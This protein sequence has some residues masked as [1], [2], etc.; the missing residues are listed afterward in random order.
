MARLP[1]EQYEFVQDTREKA[2]T[3]RSARRTRT[4]CGKGG[5]V[6]LP[7]DYMTK[8]ELEAMNGEC[9]SYRMNDSITWDEFKTW[10]KEH[11]E[12][13]IKLIRK[14]F[15]APISAISAMFGLYRNSLNKYI[16]DNELN[17][18]DIKAKRYTWDRDGFLAWCGM[19]KCDEATTSEISEEHEEIPTPEE[20]YVKENDSIA[21]CCG[22][23]EV[24]NAIPE[25]GEMTF[26][27]D[28]ND[29]LRTIGKLLNG[30]QVKL[31]VEWEVF[32]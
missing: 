26:E 20:E 15:N 31:E 24:H 12:S 23:G 18:G 14:K 4:H 22:E 3:A 8:K 29:I 27:G 5:R 10:P 9:V 13:Y 19:V 16:H 17:V 21:E 7:S 32:G 25:R 28:I 2:I 6:K 30:G 1:D 11:Q